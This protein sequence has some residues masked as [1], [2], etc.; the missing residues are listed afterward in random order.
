[1]DVFGP[2]LVVDCYTPV[3][4]AG[5]RKLDHGARRIGSIEDRCPLIIRRTAIAQFDDK[6]GKSWRVPLA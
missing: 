4:V 1:M 2:L 3:F 5:L 6:P